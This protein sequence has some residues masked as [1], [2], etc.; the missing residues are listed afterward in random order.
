MTKQ[1]AKAEKNNSTFDKS[2]LFQPNDETEEVEVPPYGT[3]TIRSLT[4]VEAMD[5]GK[6]DGAAQIEQAIIAYGCVDPALSR[7]DVK[8]WQ[9][10]ASAMALEP[11]ST[12]IAELSGLDDSAERGAVRRFPDETGD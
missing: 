5:L 3:F 9:E 8:R 2:V 6:I 10:N 11:L 4:R 7:A 1:G 12:A